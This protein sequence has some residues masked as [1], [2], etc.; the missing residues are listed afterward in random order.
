M[1][2]VIKGSKMTKQRSLLVVEDDLAVREAISRVLQTE[3]Y[4]V[5][6]AASGEDAI[7]R[8]NEN[9]IDIVLLDLTLGTVDGWRVFEALKAQ[10]PELPIIVTSARSDDLAHSSANGAS[11][12]LEKPFDVPTLLDLLEQAGRPA[13]LR[14]PSKQ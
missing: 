1:E 4:C 8:F 9:H 6:T 11:A 10:R 5:S 2:R 12:A 3:D 14:A 7:L 13:K